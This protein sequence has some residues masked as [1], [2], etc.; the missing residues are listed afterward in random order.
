MGLLG[1]I[2][3]DKELELL[4]DFWFI[5]FAIVTVV[6]INCGGMVLCFRRKKY[7]CLFALCELLHLILYAAQMYIFVVNHDV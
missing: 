3:V 4:S 7:V 5:A 1:F 6:T 2:R